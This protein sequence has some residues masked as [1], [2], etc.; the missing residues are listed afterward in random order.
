MDQ[1]VRHA[2]EQAVRRERRV[3]VL[4]VSRETLALQ[5]EEVSYETL[6]LET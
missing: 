1:C 3:I 2:I 6:V 4:E 5:L